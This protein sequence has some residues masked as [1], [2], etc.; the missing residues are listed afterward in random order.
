MNVNQIATIDWSALWYVKV[1]C[2]NKFVPFGIAHGNESFYWIHLNCVQVGF[3]CFKKFE[4][5]K[6]K[7]FPNHLQCWHF[8]K[9]TNVHIHLFRFFPTPILIIMM[10]NEFTSAHLGKFIGFKWFFKLTSHFSCS[11]TS[12][13]LPQKSGNF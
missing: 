9:K 1:K 4:N 7:Q 2:V 13:Y 10:S 11:S 6:P 5:T 8:E 12:N 3:F